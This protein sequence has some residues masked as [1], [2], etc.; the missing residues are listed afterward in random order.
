MLRREIIVNRDYQRSSKVWPP[1]ARSFL[2]ETILLGYPIPKLSLSQFTDIKSRTTVKEI[3][4]GQQRS[5]TI[6]DFFEDKFQISRNSEIEGAA[7]KIYSELDDIHKGSF[8]SY[9][10]SVDLFVSAT[11]DQI[12]E[13]F[14]RINSYTVPLNA[15]E[16][17]HSIYQG[18]FKWF[19]YYLSRRYDQSL[20][21][22]GVFKEKQLARMADSK[23]F[24]EISFALIYGIN[25]TIGKDLDNLYK[26]FDD[27]FDE[28]REIKQR[29]NQAMNLIF[30]LEDIHKTALMRSHLFYALLLAISHIQKPVS[31]LLSIYKPRQ[32][33]KPSPNLESQLPFVLPRLTA[34]A[35]AVDSGEN[36]PPKYKGFVVAATS[37]T[38]N[39][40][41][42]REIIFKT[43]CEALESST[44]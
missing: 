42:K 44:P 25:T 28:E 31:K 22:T 11:P 29:V 23:L 13:I 2:I 27:L 40:A 20:V 1:A 4:D 7:G 12:R 21:D 9:A 41:T 34:L 36:I 14:R 39:Q 37:G 19:I 8:V 6:L 32:Y 17:R 43:L 16:K 3:I 18:A 33:P 15:E 10:L 24:S 30:I 38:T 26:K 35:E 5:Q